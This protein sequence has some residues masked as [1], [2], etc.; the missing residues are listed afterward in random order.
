MK[1]ILFLTV[2]VVILSPRPVSANLWVYEYIPGEKVIFDT[3]TEN[4]WYRHLPDFVSM[5]YGEQITKIAGLGTY[6]HI[7]GGW[8]MASWEEITALW[9][10]YS[11]QLLSLAFTETD[12]DPLGRSHLGRYEYSDTVGLH[13]VGYMHDD[14]N[15]RGLDG[16]VSDD[17]RFDSVGAWVTS[18][19]PVVPVPGALILTATGLLSMLGFKRW[20]GKH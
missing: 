10:G 16:L 4:Y 17:W 5:T 11:G 1:R 6:G 18:D 8:H 20:R 9:A 14:G 3:K 2:A 15:I 13:Y 12:I 19:S 7:D